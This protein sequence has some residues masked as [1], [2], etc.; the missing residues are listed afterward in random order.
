M[1]RLSLLE[2]LGREV[3]TQP[4]PGVAHGMPHVCT[5]KPSFMQHADA[6]HVACGEVRQAWQ[7]C[8]TC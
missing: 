6:E 4:L 2:M 1:P 5:S 8:G 7:Q 3:A